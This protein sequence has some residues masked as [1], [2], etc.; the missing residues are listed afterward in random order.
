MTQKSKT[1]DLKTYLILNLDNNYWC[2][3]PETDWNYDEL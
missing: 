1:Q 3:T 2:T